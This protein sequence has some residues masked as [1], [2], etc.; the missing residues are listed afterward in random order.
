MGELGIPALTCHPLGSDIHCASVIFAL[1][2]DT[3]G[4]HVHICVLPGVQV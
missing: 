1:S 4:C 2:P 3:G